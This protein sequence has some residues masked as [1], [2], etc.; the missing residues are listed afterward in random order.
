MKRWI[1]EVEEAVYMYD[2]YVDND[3]KLKFWE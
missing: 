3:Q 1:L 2:D